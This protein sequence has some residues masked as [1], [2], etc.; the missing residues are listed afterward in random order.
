MAKKIKVSRKKIKRPD[1][2][3]S[4]SDRAI[5]YLRANKNLVYGV[6]SGVI[7]AVLAFNLVNYSLS[8]RR[9]KSEALLTEAFSILNTPL[10]D[11]MTSEQILKGSKTYATGKQRSEEAISKL[12]EVVQKF[13]SGTTGLEARYRLGEV[14]FQNGEFA[15]GVAA[16]QDFLKEFKARKDQPEFL[17]YSA[18]V[19]LG[20]NYYELADYPK[21][22]ENF[23]KVVD[24]KKGG[25]Y[26][27]EASLGLA[28]SLIKLKDF[29]KAK[30]H[31]D[32]VVAQSPGTIYEELAR[33][34]MAKLPA[35]AGAK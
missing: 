27:A 20:K 3:L 29:A 21:A 12:N 4:G 14:Y 9:I 30:E 28:R 32:S 11:Q 7:L 5:K 26:S 8:S 16:Y 19:G 24:S 17:E 6:A 22:V 1:E 2:F 15:K 23:T 34:E 13:G 33:L 31:L 18:Y 25:A 10:T 35:S